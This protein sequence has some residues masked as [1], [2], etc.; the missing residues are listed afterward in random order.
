MLLKQVFQSLAGVQKRVAFEN[1]HANP[2]WSYTAVRCVGPDSHR[3]TAEYD[4]SGKTKYTYRIEK[5]R[6]RT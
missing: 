1:A 5:V 6:C 4:F 2:G 3:D